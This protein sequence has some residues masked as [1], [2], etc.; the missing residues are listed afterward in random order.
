MQ[1]M[2]PYL[3]G[4]ACTVFLIA[5]LTRN[6]SQV[7]KLW[8]L[9]PVAFSW[10]HT[11]LGGGQ[12]MVLMS[13]VATVWGLR[14]SFNFWRKGGYSWP[15]WAGEED[16]RWAA[17]WKWPGMGNPVSKFLFNLLFIS[18]YQVALI[19]LF[20]CPSLAALHQPIQPTDWALAAFYLSLVV[21]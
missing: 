3:C 6:Y 14:L 13:A 21:I 20:S 18:A 7:D 17:V 15:P 1:S 5:E 11:W 4:L 10:G 19:Y 9:L 8:S 16:Y 2:L 12:K